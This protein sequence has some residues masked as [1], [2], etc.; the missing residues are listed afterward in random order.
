[1]TDRKLKVLSLFAGIGGFDLGLERTGGFR[2]VA[3][4][5][6]DARLWACLSMHWPEVPIYADIKFLSADAGFADVVCGGF[7][8]QP[9]STASAGRRKGAA[10]DRALWPEMLRLVSECQPAWVVC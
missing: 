2:T 8:C 5:E 10:D 6:I 7:P 3:F 1:M 4:C 9:Y